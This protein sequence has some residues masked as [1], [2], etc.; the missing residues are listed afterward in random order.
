MDMEMIFP[1]EEES[2]TRGSLLKHIALRISGG[3]RT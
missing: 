1:H 2:K 3:D